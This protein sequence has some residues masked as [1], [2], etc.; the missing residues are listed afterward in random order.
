MPHCRARNGPLARA[1]GTSQSAA[2]LLDPGLDELDHQRGKAAEV[3]G[4]RD[5]ALWNSVKTQVLSVLDN[6]AKRVRL[7][8]PEARV[9]TES[10][11]NDAFPLWSILRMSVVRVGNGRFSLD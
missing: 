3:T 10:A 7:T 4:T 6:V 11:Y 1:G 5:P 9:V 2:S 8:L